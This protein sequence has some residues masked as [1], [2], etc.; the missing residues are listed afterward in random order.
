MFE[1]TEQRAIE[2]VQRARAKAE[3]ARRAYT[4]AARAS[5]SSEDAKA[6]ALLGE[7]KQA[8]AAL[9]AARAALDACVI[10]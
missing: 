6:A 1:P 4:A 10:V 8:A 9:D 5:T 3:D 2:A 7:W